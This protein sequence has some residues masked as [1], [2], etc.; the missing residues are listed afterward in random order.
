MSDYSFMTFNKT[1][2]VMRTYDMLGRAQIARDL[3][4]KPIGLGA[5]CGAA[6]KYPSRYTDQ[7]AALVKQAEISYNGIYPFPY[8]G[9]AGIQSDAHKKMIYMDH[10]ATTPLHPAVKSVMTEALDIFGNPSS[11]HAIGRQA[12]EHIER[13]R[14]TVADLI[15]AAS[16]EI[17]FTGSGSEANAMVLSGWLYASDVYRKDII[18]SRIEHAC[19][20]ESVRWLEKHGVTV[21]YLDVDRYGRIDPNQ[22]HDMMRDTTGLV[23]VMMANNE[24]GTLQDI[25]ALA[26]IAHEHGALFHTDAVQAV[27]KI[28]VD[29]RVLGVDYLTM[30]AH[31]LYGP[32]GVG[33][34]YVRRGVPCIPLIR[35]GQQEYRRRAGTEHTLGIIGFGKAV[36]VC[37]QDMVE[38]GQRIRELSGILKHTIACNISDVIYNGHPTECLPGTVSVSFAGV[39]SEAVVLA[40]DLAGIAVSTGSA[41]SAGSLD[42]S[43]VLLATGMPSEHARGTVRISLGRETTIDDV[44]YAAHSLESIM[45]RLRGITVS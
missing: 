22:L 28:P 8:P 35:G 30:A 19:V 1:H 2:E 44:Q 3:I 40:L 11:V 4:V 13:A 9:T 34:V 5:G 43:H 36:D 25:Q 23:S 21:S 32:K 41:C 15:G 18:T 39:E 24:I 12:A 38:E 37:K 42:P 27:G 6:I 16:K 29:V 14:T 7:V 10:N 26:A 17:V 31:K 20:L 33:A 45:S